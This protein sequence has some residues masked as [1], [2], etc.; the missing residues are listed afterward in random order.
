M[1]YKANMQLEYDVRT[2]NVWLPKNYK[3]EHKK[4]MHK[5]QKKN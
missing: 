5:K 3:I 2:V 1:P 4:H